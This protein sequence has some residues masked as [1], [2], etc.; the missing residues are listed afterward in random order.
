MVK[1][2]IV[3]TG[4]E[5]EMIAAGAHVAIPYGIVDLGTQY[6][7]KFDKSARKVRILFEFPNALQAEGKFAGQPF[8]LAKNYTNLLVDKSNLMKDL[9]RWR[10]KPFTKEQLEKFDLSKLLG[11]PCMANVIH[12]DKKQS[13]GV[14]AAIDSLSGVPV[15]M[16]V[17]KLTNNM[18]IFSLDDF[19]QA[20]FDAQPEFVKE[21]IVAS[22]EYKA[23]SSE[24]LAAHTSKSDDGEDSDI[25]F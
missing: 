14:Y 17:P 6:Q 8:V 5:Y 2:F 19:D 18:F 10:G 16:N 12:Q 22:P 20:T 9:V 13:S 23:L 4:T 15:G 11:V 3:P 1:P 25:P 7:E 21:I 24:G